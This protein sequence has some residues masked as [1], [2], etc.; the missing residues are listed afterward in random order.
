MK[1][2]WFFFFI[3]STYIFAFLLYFRILINISH[4]FTYYNVQE[5]NFRTVNWTKPRSKE[6]KTRFNETLCE[7]KKLSFNFET[8]YGNRNNKI[9]PN[10]L[11]ANNVRYLYLYIIL[12]TW[13]TIYLSSMNQGAHK[14]IQIICTCNYTKFFPLCCNIEKINSF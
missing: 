9:V 10:F 7:P 6:K 1:F 14:I 4:Y 8:I 13:K 2:I 11:D 5:Y 12:I 3:L